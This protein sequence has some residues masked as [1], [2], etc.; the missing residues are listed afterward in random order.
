VVLPELE[1]IRKKRNALGLSQEKLA[2]ELTLSGVKFSRVV[3]NRI[4]NRNRNENTKKYSPSYDHAKIIFDYLENEEILKKMKH[5]KTAGKICAVIKMGKTTVSPRDTIKTT[6]ER[7][8]PKGLSQL[9]VIDNG[10]CIGL[11]TIDSI[12]N[13]K[14][15]KKV[16]EAMINP[17][18]IISEDEIIT[19]QIRVF[20][21]NSPCILVF[22]KNSTSIKGIITEWDLLDKLYD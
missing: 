9:P 8:K 2:T 7:M 15:A 21:F 10:N 6:K 1:K 18:P 11:I 4:E 14:N 20:L 19:P 12:L 22:H 16:K 17:P 13:S 5:G 3:I